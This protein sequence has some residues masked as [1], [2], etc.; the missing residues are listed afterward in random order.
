[1]SSDLAAELAAAAATPSGRLR[2]VVTPTVLQM[3][4]VECGAAALAMVLAYHG[5]IAS[6][7]ELRLA[8]GIS[9]DG[10]KATNLVRA[11]KSYGLTA[12]GF[13][14][15][16]AALR[17]LEPPMILHW[18]FNHFVVLDGFS[19]KGAHINDPACGPVVVSGEELDRAFTGVVLTFE[20]SDTFQRG[21]EPPS[22]FGA[23]RRRV[24]GSGGAL[25]FVVLAG[26]ALVM[27]GLIAASFSK[28]FVDEVII[29][30]LTTWA[31]PLALS[32]V[33][34]AAI[35]FILTALQQRYLLRLESRLSL[36]GSSQFL[37]HVLRLPIRFF[38]QR[39][40][41]DIANRV[42]INDSVSRVLSGDLARTAVAL[43]V[44]GLYAVL[45]F[46]YDVLLTVVG[47]VT[48]LLNLLALRYASKKRV[49]L[50]Q[51]LGQ[52][53]GRMIGTAMGALQTIDTLK[54]TG[55][56]SDFF[57]RWSGYQAKVAI[58]QQQLALTTLVLSAAPP[59]LMAINTALIL[60]LGGARI[61]DGYLTMGMLIAFQ[62]LLVAFLGP[63]NQMVNLGGTLQEVKGDMLRL[64][65][66]LRARTDRGLEQPLGRANGPTQRPKL[67]G[68][69]EL[70]DV[71]FGYSP[72]D[73]PLIEGFSLTLR[74]GGRVALVGGSGSGKSTVA[75]LLT[76]QQEPWS[77]EV[78]FDG[79]PRNMIDRETLVQSLAMVDQDICLF[80]D[81]I[82]AN[83]TMWD[84]TVAE[85]DL[86]S[87]ARD[88]C[89]H[90]EVATRPGAYGGAVEEG[91]RNFSGGQRQRMELA[92][93]L[94]TNPTI[95]VLDEATS[96]L[97][98]TTEKIVDDNLR[99]RGCT[100]II[101][102]HRLSTIRDCDEILV[103]DK[104]R[105]VERGTHDQMM[106]SSGPYR[107][108]I[109]AEG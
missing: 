4:A 101:V 29:H 11:A 95:L 77:G 103:L 59:L 79:V 53:R 16:P 56:E 88:A 64:D 81:S 45:L 96:A 46:Q 33:A 55:A 61:M 93:A 38:T 15:E 50:T 32:M 76:G 51:R 107:A 80:E 31:Q 14:K 48:V 71:T 30:G 100:C 39:Y 92:R 86:V 41:G 73:P 37:W 106:A 2:R 35:I 8:C 23:L 36:H 97:D 43:L 63:A 82:R 90:E 25:A 28:I 5:R 20:R 42:A 78:L 26:L 58:G 24:A 84:G 74:P 22:L 108:L 7:E 47:I 104:G 89:L 105:I 70:R 75:R 91:G 27:P 85:A 67:A 102:A 62:S 109:S 49:T 66:V 18:N 83:L 54:A 21:G 3:E 94:A 1:M 69:V 9:R 65:D 12:K 98:P 44:V 34:I 60:G 57:A 40:A 10:S 17:Q 52:D 87:A 99:R 6:L 13:K 68:A 19:K 72:L